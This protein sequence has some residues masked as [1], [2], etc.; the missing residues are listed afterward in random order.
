MSGELPAPA[1]LITGAA[2][3]LG[4]ALCSAF[5]AAGYRVV[6]SDHQEL[7]PDVPHDVFEY[8]A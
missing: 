3:G 5:H 8:V 1:A 7:P 6:A 2:G 4:G